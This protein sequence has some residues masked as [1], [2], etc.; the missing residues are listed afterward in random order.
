MANDQHQE[1]FQ[2]IKDKY[3]SRFLPTAR[4]LEEHLAVLDF[5]SIAAIAHRF[6]GSALPY[7]YPE[8]GEIAGA[9]S[10][11]ISSGDQPVDTLKSATLRF[12]DTLKREALI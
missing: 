2:V 9:L 3:L 10:E 4:E 5:D 11:L 8:I 12:V 6:N 7:G 1:R